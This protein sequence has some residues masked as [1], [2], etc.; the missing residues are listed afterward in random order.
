VFPIIPMTEFFREIQ[1]QEKEKAEAGRRGR[2]GAGGDVT[3][4]R[5]IAEGIKLAKRQQAVQAARGAA[6]GLVG[7]SGGASMWDYYKVLGHDGK[8]KA[9]PE[10]SDYSEALEQ[11]ISQGIGMTSRRLAGGVAVGGPAASGLTGA[12]LAAV[13]ARESLD[14]E[15]RRIRAAT[16][17]AEYGQHGHHRSH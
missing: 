3:L 4:D 1:R 13:P 2:E 11:L 9:Q 12:H 17:R 15:R 8:L 14:E 7:G 6:A 5:V 16:S 10:P